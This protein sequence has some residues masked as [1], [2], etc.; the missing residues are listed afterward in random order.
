MRFRMTAAEWRARLGSVSSYG[1][2][3]LVDASRI[4]SFPNFA[5]LPADELDELAAAMSE[6]DKT[7]TVLKPPL[8]NADIADKSDLTAMSL[9]KPIANN[10]R[11]LAGGG[12]LLLL[13]GAAWPSRS[14][15][16]RFTRKMRSR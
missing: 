5:D 16:L 1:T 6:L 10:W 11:W 7:V 3:H 15:W 13:A 8:D 2:M 14:K 4:A 9:T 12:A